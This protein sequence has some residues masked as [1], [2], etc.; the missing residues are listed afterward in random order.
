MI[1]RQDTI[2]REVARKA[3][4]RAFR[5]ARAA[6]KP[7]SW[8]EARKCG[9]AHARSMALPQLPRW[10]TAEQAKDLR[11]ASSARPK[12]LPRYKRDPHGEWWTN[13]RADLVEARR[14]V[15]VPE[16]SPRAGRRIKARG[17]R[18]EREVKREGYTE[19]EKTE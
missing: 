13:K 14:Y 19:P 17:K 9:L 18:P 4:K 6:G 3:T 5:K 1:L 12:T 8:S 16:Y 11:I 10:P 2:D 7:I 15:T